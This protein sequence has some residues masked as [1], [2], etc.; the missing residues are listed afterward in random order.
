MTRSDLLERY[1][2]LPLPTTKDES[3]RFTDLK[4]FD[5]ETFSANGAT[6]VAAA[7]RAWRLRRA[8]SRLTTSMQSWAPQRFVA[9]FASTMPRHGASEVPLIRLWPMAGVCS[10][11]P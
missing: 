10:P 1:R 5:P 9:I 11:S 6:E 2:A 4:D 7:L 3:W 8:L